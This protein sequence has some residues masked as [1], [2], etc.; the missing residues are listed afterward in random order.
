MSLTPGAK[1]L[2]AEKGYDPNY[3]AR[4]LKRTIQK[5]IEDPMAEDIL[6]G[7]FTEGSKVRVSKKGDGL[8]FVD[9]NAG[10]GQVDDEEEVVEGKK[11]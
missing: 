6:M 5:M 3:G 11:G 4:H 9:A 1:A 8:Q 2:L 7:R 10:D